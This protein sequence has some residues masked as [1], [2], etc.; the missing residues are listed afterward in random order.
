MNKFKIEITSP[1]DRDN[2]VAEIWF[3]D[4]HVGEINTESGDYEIE[5]Y[6]PV[7]MEYWT[8]VLEEFLEA[9]QEGK[10]RLA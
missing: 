7:K 3:G 1:P 5:L 6:K 2:L 9:L 8:F 10:K 4:N